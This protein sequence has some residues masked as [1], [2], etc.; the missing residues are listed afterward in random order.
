MEA[1][2]QGW[3]ARLHS[4]LHCSAKYCWPPM[5]CFIAFYPL[6][7]MEWVAALSWYASCLTYGLIGAF[8]VRP[9]LRPSGSF[10]VHVWR[11]S[12]RQAANR[13]AWQKQAWA[14][15]IASKLGVSMLR[16]GCQFGLQIRPQGTLNRHSLLFRYYGMG[17]ARSLPPRVEWAHPV[18]W[19]IRLLGDNVL[20]GGMFQRVIDL[21]FPTVH[22]HDK[23][24]SHGWITFT[25]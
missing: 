22:S 8:T 6:S 14:H 16:I 24:C 21:I 23:E 2:L 7:W 12:A 20:Y 5:A 17:P 11:L 9:L 13:P 25:L 3:C 1:E 10:L 18:G 15:S 19:A 4:F